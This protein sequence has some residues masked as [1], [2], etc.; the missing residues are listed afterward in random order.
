MATYGIYQVLDP[1]YVTPSGSVC[2]AQIIGGEAE[3]RIAAKV[4]HP[5]KA[6]PDEPNWEPK[7]FLDRAQV[8]RRVA[9]AGGA[10]WAPVYASGF[11]PE[12]GAY[13]ITDYHA[14]TARKLVEGRVALDAAALHAVVSSVTAG[15]DEIRRI[16]GR[17]HA[18]LKP[19]NVLLLGKGKLDELRALLCDPGQEY[20]AQKEGEAGDLHA[21]GRL[22]HELVV[23]RAPGSPGDLPA[24]GAA[25][26][27]R[28]GDKG[29]AW[30]QLCVDLCS[31]PVPPRA[32]TLAAAAKVISGLAPPRVKAPRFRLPGSAR[33]PASKAANAA[34]ARPRGPRGPSRWKRTLVQSL[35]VLLL[36]GTGLGVFA[37]M[38]SS[39]REEVCQARGSWFGALE[40]GLS[41]P[42]RRQRFEDDPHMR[43]VVDGVEQVRRAGVECDGGQL[44]PL[45]FLAYT[46]TRAATAALRQVELDLDPEAWPRLQSLRELGT[47]LEKRGWQQP[48][49]YVGQLVEGVRPTPATASAARSRP[50]VP[51]AAGGNKA[52]G[53]GG[54]EDEAAP[55]PVGGGLAERI[56]RVL[57]LQPIIEEQAAAAA[58][59][60]E[61][62]NETAGNLERSGDP[63]VQSF[64]TLLRGQAVAAVRLTDEG[65][66]GLAALDKHALLA[67][68]V[69]AALR[70]DPERPVDTARFAAE[71]VE[72]HI[73]VNELELADV[74][75]WLKQRP[76]YAV[77][78]DEVG[79]EAERLNKQFSAMRAKVAKSVPL[80]TERKAFALAEVNVESALR[81]FSRTPFIEADIAGGAFAEKV[82]KIEVQIADIERYYHAENPE[83]WLKNLAGVQ[84]SS[85]RIQR[86]WDTW[87]QTLR[88]D[89]SS[90]AENRELFAENE[91]RTIKLRDMLT[92]IDV[93]LPQPSD[94]LSDTFKAAAVQR[95]EERMGELLAKVNPAAPEL[96]PEVLTATSQ[97]LQAWFDSLGA[98]NAQFPIPGTKLL[99]LEERPDEVWL[100]KDEAF[101]LDPL[102]QSLVRP[103]LERIQRLQKVRGANRAQLVKDATA[104]VRPEVTFAAWQELG[105]PRVRPAWPSTVDE[106]SV[107]AKLR[108]RVQAEI[109]KLGD[110]ERETLQDTLDQEGPRRWRR[111]VEAITPEGAETKLEAA[112]TLWPTFKMSNTALAEMEAP[113]RFNFWL[114]LAN[115]SVRVDNPNDEAVRKAMDN[116]LL[117]AADLKKGQQDR[118]AAVRSKLA[119]LEAPEPFAGRKLNDVF[120]LSVQGL[121]R[122]IEFRRVEQKSGGRPFYLG[123]SEVTL[124][125]F[126]GALD[127]AR[128]WD[129]SLRLDWAY[130]PGK[131]DRRRG[132]RGWEWT[133]GPGGLPTLDPSELWM[134]DLQDGKHND[135]PVE[136][137]ERRF[138][139]N[140][141]GP[142]FGG[143]PS[144]R[145][146]IQ[147]ISAQAALYYAA[148]LGCR[149]PSSAEWRAALEA[150]GQTPE[151]GRWN[152]RDQTWEAFRTH[153]AKEAIPADRWPDAGAFPDDPP[154]QAGD[155]PPPGRPGN[156]STLLFRPVPAADGTFH[157]LVG[158]VAEY[159]CEAPQAFE[160]WPDKGSAS[161]LKRFLGDTP[162]AVAVIGGSALSAPDAPLAEAL[163]VKQTHRGYSDVGLRLAFTAPAQNLAERLK[164]V[165]AGE[166]YLPPE[167]TASASTGGD[168]GQ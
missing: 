131:P 95:R 64:G 37:A 89:A 121:R 153:A 103:D 105:T 132:P 75:T 69:L 40:T 168:A 4:F 42:Q 56:E 158:N 133:G 65:F 114:Y 77:R 68:Q 32:A 162:G 113:A 143:M 43:R 110:F 78:K 161:D 142:T 2:S 7:Y 72:P 59:Q 111:F 166:Q 112:Y 47:T 35:A 163:P 117:A 28:L 138:N 46:K 19:S 1:L 115:Q 88:D 82:T 36:V 140:V 83:D 122:P 21:L 151:N 52:M 148:A 96:A 66:E 139:R 159:V 60:W 146:P 127:G 92:E 38:E 14:L 93:L 15:L 100:K 141:I 109:Q 34:A 144:Q 76:R 53:R 23:H 48:A 167:R 155:A 17:S 134:T 108:D 11:T 87:V 90:M 81:E 9:A 119:K 27:A 157:D 130:Q 135:F 129:E 84:T 106:L 67:G 30:R 154:R 128:L 102:V 120:A 156:D 118:A 6:D 22:I 49:G 20:K 150:G 160:D 13:Y 58:P 70:D 99:T 26:W 147:Y 98:L 51:A 74:Q 39:A 44:R 85:D 152:L 33:P 124:A 54:D 18:N 80:A 10:H 136:F 125:E 41:E 5:P 24:A 137:R 45:G 63:V 8:Q 149:L 116:L 104:E 79:R 29:E 55:L 61:R 123:T 91:A 50:S 62:L 126:V 71:V 101:W 31:Q 12:G 16:A 94:K 107:E 3:G 86:A 97:S 165:L 25:E 164:W 57:R 145:H 73:N